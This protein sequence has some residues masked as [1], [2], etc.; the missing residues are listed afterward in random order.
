MAN[1]YSQLYV[2]FV[3]AVKFRQA[4]IPKEQKEMVHKYIT[5]I[6]Q[7][8]GQKLLAIHAMPDHIH[9]FVNFK[10]DCCLS[11]LMRDVKTAS[12]QFINEQPWMRTQF[13]W[14]NGFGAFSYAKSQISNVCR[15]IERQ[16]EHHA[17]KSFKAEYL[18][19]LK[20][21]EIEYED[22]YLFDF[23]EDAT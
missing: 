9:I 8:R 7:K 23:F 13:R 22:Q 15:Y 14:Q 11:D 5:G 19:F 10:P 4:L 21:F 12:S 6:I 3:F 18:D 2:Q 16:E 1:T 20:K 17:K